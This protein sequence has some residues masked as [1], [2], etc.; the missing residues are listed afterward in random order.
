MPVGRGDTWIITNPEF[1]IGEKAAAYPGGSGNKTFHEETVF[2]ADIRL[3]GSDTLFCEP[4]PAVSISRKG[5]KIKSIH[6]SPIEGQQLKFPALSGNSRRENRNP[7]NKKYRPVIRNPEK[8]GPFTTE[9]PEPEFA[10]A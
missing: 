1:P 10:S 5:G 2:Q 4:S 3:P 8:Q 6:R 9:A 7:G